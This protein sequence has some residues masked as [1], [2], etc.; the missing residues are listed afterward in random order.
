MDQKTPALADSPANFTLMNRCIQWGTSGPPMLPSVYDSNYH[1][2]QNRNYVLIF[3]ETIHDV[4]FIPLDGRPHLPDDVRQL[5][6]DSRGH[7]EGNTL[8]VDTTNFSDETNFRNASTHLH[9]VERFTRVAPHVLLYEFSV[10]DP[11]AFT[12]PFT[13]FVAMTTIKGPLFEYAC[14]EGNYALADIMRAARLEEKRRAEKSS[15]EP[16]PNSREGGSGQQ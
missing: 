13:G 6:G 16:K 5:A 8:V 14:N 1:I 2:V 3:T 9:V 11:T 10:D 7:W 12:A 15:G 4:R